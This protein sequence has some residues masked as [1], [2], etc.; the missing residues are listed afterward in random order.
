MK[1]HHV[2]D[3][4]DMVHKPEVFARIEERYRDPVLRAESLRRLKRA[5]GAEGLLG[6]GEDHSTARKGGDY[7]LQDGVRYRSA[8]DPVDEGAHILRDW[9]GSGWG[10]T[11][12]N[13][14]D[15]AR[16]ALIQT[17]ETIDKLEARKKRGVTVPV[18]FVWICVP[19]P[20]KFEASVFWNDHS[21]TT[22]FVTGPTPMPQGEEGKQKRVDR[23]RKEPGW[24]IVRNG[25]DGTPEVVGP[26]IWA[27][28]PP[29]AKQKKRKPA[30]RKRG[31]KK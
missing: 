24:V 3:M 9:F 7:I 29:I 21:V 26:T 20:G 1:G 27:V 18:Q 19:D 12:P 31:A 28:P 25:E 6:V 22:V 11:A 5:R 10:W 23:Q 4:P 8:A 13:R 30:A 2:V 15:I 16:R 14:P 17:I